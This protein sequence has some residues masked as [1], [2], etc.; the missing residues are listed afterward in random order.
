MPDWTVAKS[1]MDRMSLFLPQ[2]SPEAFGL[3]RDLPL[4]IKV[5]CTVLA[6]CQGFND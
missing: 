1:S 4:S 3:R 5:N 2:N 6:E